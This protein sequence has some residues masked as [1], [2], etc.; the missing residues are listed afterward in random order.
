VQFRFVFRLN[1][2]GLGLLNAQIHCK[3]HNF[4]PNSNPSNQVSQ[5]SQKISN[6]TEKSQFMTKYR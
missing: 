2:I 6:Q 4:A 3:F 1:L 5:A